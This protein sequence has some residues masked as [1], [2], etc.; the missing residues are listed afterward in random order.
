ME[1]L[2]GFFV[3]CEQLAQDIETLKSR[4]VSDE[5]PNY[6]S[7]ALHVYRLNKNVDRAEHCE[8]RSTST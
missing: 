7:D 1:S 8:G 6:S 5:D 4:T 3:V 2:L